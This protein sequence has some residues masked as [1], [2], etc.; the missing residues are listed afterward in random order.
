M[1][2]IASQIIKIDISGFIL[3]ILKV[4]IIHD[5]NF[6]IINFVIFIDFLLS[7]RKFEL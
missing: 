4:N 5:L 3:K 1:F 7:R 6:L 2:K